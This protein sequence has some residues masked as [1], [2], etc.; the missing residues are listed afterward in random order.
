MSPKKKILWLILGATVAVIALSIAIATIVITRVTPSPVPL[1]QPEGPVL[2]ATNQNERTVTVVEVRT[3]RFV[4]NIPVGDSP[5]EIAASPNGHWA[6]ATLP[7]SFNFFQALRGA[8]GD[9]LVV[10]DVAT[11]TLRRT[12]DLGE[13]S[14][15]HGIAFLSDNRT[16]VATSGPRQ[17][18]VLADIEAGA[19]LD[20]ISAG[21]NAR[22]HILAV[23]GDRQSVYSANLEG[24]TISEIDVAARTLRRA[25]PF[26]GE[27]VVIAVPPDGGGAWVI[28]CDKYGRYTLAVVD[29]AT[30]AI[31]ARFD[32]FELPRRVGI[33][34]DSA[35]ALI[36]DPERDE[37]RIYDAPARR[38]LGRV[39]TGEG[40]GPSGVSFAPDSRLAYVALQSG[41]IAEIDL[42][43]QT[44][45]RRFKTTR[46]GLDGL[47]YI[48][49]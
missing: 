49:R 16:V 39:S 12:I 43:A 4:A 17:S 28:E 33:S 9:K 23:S 6:V 36:T 25:I 21:S 41:E 2:L 5:H 15:P 10:I 32:G 3:G 22:P 42:I 20:A 48:H 8:G 24:G 14:S 1:I 30:G 47:V 7:G 35:L 18:V 40:T 11:A 31:V 26:P 38:E 44:V 19:A 29:L 46:T 37:I 34:P 27:P 13:D 45:A